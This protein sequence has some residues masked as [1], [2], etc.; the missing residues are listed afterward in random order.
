MIIKLLS[1]SNGVRFPGMSHKVI[2]MS[3]FKSTPLWF[4]KKCHSQSRGSFVHKNRIGWKLRLNNKQC[5]DSMEFAQKSLWF[6]YLFQLIVSRNGNTKN[7]PQAWGPENMS[8][9]IEYSTF[10][11]H[12]TEI[13]S[14]NWTRNMVSCSVS[15]FASAF[16]STNI[17][18]ILTSSSL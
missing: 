7:I 2:S 5:D 6:S 10:I 3:H 17:S 12:I 13:A 1:N 4:P 9:S 14:E 18:L 16:G 15:P 11:N 8:K